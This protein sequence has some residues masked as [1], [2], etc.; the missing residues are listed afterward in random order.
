MESK[1]N[2]P[3]LDLPAVGPV[4]PPQDVPQGIAAKW[5]A[6]VNRES[7]Y[8]ISVCFQH[9]DSQRSLAGIRV[10]EDLVAQE[11][12]RPRC[13]NSRLAAR[14]GLHRDEPIQS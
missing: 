12:E 2:R 13:Q 4:V 5:P 9:F 11:D 3:P 8:R 10:D 6:V 14:A 1:S 7:V